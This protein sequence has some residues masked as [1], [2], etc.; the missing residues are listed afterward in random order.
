MLLDVGKGG[1]GELNYYIKREKDVKGCR[2]YMEG[3]A[4]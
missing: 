3:P 2:N 1:E 4:G